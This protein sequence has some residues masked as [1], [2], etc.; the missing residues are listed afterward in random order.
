MR[1]LLLPMFGMLGVMARHG[2]GV[3]ASGIIRDPFPIATMSI[4]VVGSFLIG[5]VYALGVEQSVLS[6]LWKQ[7][8]MVGFLGGFTTFS[9]FS[10]ETVQLLEREHTLRA[11]AYVGLSPLLGVAATFMGLILARL[12]VAKGG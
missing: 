11:W 12:W 10:L 1:Y 8:I 5:V 3:A 9:A 2:V 4:N 7:A 6:P